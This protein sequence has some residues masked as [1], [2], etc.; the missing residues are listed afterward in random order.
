[1]KYPLVGRMPQ[2]TLNQVCWA[3]RTNIKCI[4]C[5]VYCPIFTRWP[6]DS[7]LK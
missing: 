4:F 3:I 5:Q 2:M 6:A 1:M 7:W